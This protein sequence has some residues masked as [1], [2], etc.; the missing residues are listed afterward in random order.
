M[1]SAEYA[2][3]IQ[4]TVAVKPMLVISFHNPF[5][6]IY[7]GTKVYACTNTHIDTHKI[8]TDFMGIPTENNLPIILKN[9]LR[10]I[11]SLSYLS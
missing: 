9:W 1:G 5:R 11:G 4:Y 2:S 3:I 6:P 10:S 8:L 7:I